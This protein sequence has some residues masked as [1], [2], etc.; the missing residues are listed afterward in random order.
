MSKKL[1]ARLAVDSGVLRIG[2]PCYEVPNDASTGEKGELE[3][4]G[5]LLGVPVSQALDLPTTYGDGI[6]AV[7]GHYNGHELIGLY[8]DLGN[9]FA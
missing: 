8:I 1:I 6:Y 4:L 5:K 9:N 7:I 2:D 3:H